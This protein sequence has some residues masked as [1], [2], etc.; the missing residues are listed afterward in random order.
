MDYNKIIYQ[1]RLEQ[2][3]CIELG[4]PPSVSDDDIIYMSNLI[5][6]YNFVGRT[7]IQK[8]IIRNELNRLSQGT[9][10]YN[11]FTQDLFEGYFNLQ[12]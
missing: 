9:S 1:L 5:H 2:I 4:L 10:Y 11:S 6:S 8:I 3:Q 12:V 7:D